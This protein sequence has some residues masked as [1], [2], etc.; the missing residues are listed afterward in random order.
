[1]SKV[2]PLLRGCWSSAGHPIKFA[3]ILWRS[4]F[5]F[6]FLSSQ[7]HL[8]LLFLQGELWKCPPCVCACNRG[9]KL[10]IELSHQEQSRL[11]RICERSRL[12]TSMYCFLMGL[13]HLNYQEWLVIENG[14]PLDWWMV[15]TGNHTNQEPAWWWVFLVNQAG[16]FTAWWL[17]TCTKHWG[18]R[19]PPQCLVLPV[20]RL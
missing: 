16:V 7:F 2:I 1:M 10:G 8:P 12:S 20:V 9:D 17:A 5:F 6:F 19:T 14:E 4:V 13:T 18:W 3:Y 11:V 15:Y